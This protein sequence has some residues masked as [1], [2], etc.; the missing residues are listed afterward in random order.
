M[1]EIYI[2][3]EIRTNNFNDPER[4]EKV[5]ELWTKVLKK[6]GDRPKISI[7]AVY[8]LFVDGYKGNYTLALG[9]DIYESDKLVIVGDDH[10]MLKADMTEEDGVIKAW[11]RIWEMEEKEQ[12]DRAYLVD[13]ETHYTNGNV[14][15]YISVK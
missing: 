8:F 2:I 9:T 12:I 4:D 6:L 5:Q 14:E 15:L 10:L 13:Y 3:D 7:Y 11:E 1:K